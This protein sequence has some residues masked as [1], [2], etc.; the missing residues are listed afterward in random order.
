MTESTSSPARRVIVVADLVGYSTLAKPADEIAGA[1]GVAALGRRIG[2]AV[3]EALCETRAEP[4]SRKGTGD[5][6]ILVFEHAEMRERFAVALHEA[7]GRE[8]RRLED[9][10]SRSFQIGIVVGEVLVEPDGELQGFAISAVTR[11][12]GKAP[13]GR[14]FVAVDVWAELPAEVQRLYGDEETVSGK[15]EGEEYQVRRCRLSGENNRDR[16]RG[17]GE[18]DHSD[19]F[20][21]S[22]AGETDRENFCGFS[23]ATAY[24]GIGGP[25]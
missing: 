3:D 22:I 25:D 15:H 21:F 20:R 14:I 23:R 24:G 12:E 10:G 5:G 1:D 4:I 7:A 9:L 2:R 16:R 19:A 13:R 8:G 18:R 11:L 6:A 17:A